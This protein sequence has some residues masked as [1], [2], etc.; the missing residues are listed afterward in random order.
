MSTVK[1]TLA[2][3]DP[4]LDAEEREEQAQ[5]FMAEL[6][7]ME[8]E[9]ESVVPVVDPSPPE[10]NKSFGGFLPGWLMAE[11]TLGNAVKVL[12]VINDRLKGKPIAMELEGNGKKLKIS[13]GTVEDLQAAI[14]E[15]KVFLEG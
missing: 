10:G 14:Q 4:E 12:G 2:F 8:D 13:V 9:V 11:V 5:S 1:I 15:A 6:K 3:V 7:Q